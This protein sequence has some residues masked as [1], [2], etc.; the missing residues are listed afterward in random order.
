MDD[1]EFE[2]HKN[3]LLVKKLEKPKKL[4]TRNER[5]WREICAHTFNFKRVEVEA[6]ALKKVSRTDLLEFFDAHIGPEAPERR[7]L[8]THVVSTV[9]KEED[10][11]ENSQLCGQ[12]IT[13]V[14]E[15]KGCHPLHPLA[16]PFVSLSQLKREI[17]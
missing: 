11:A 1:E 4:S 10:S 13:D 15:F 8:S 6:E 7:K 16:Q 17:K 5:I 2:R 9:E 12:R 3:A 14:C